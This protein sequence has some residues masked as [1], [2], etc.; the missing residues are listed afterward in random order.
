MEKGIEACPSVHTRGLPM[1]V[2]RCVGTLSYESKM[3]KPVCTSP[4][5][6]S[7]VVTFTM[8]KEDLDW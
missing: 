4:G 3:K 5:C 2:V 7:Q 8:W 6:I 1:P